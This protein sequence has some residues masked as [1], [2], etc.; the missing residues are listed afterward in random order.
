[1]SGADYPRLP[2]S[3]YA[4]AVLDN[5]LVV[6]ETRAQVR[7]IRRELGSARARVRTL[8]CEAGCPCDSPVSYQMELVR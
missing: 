6:A 5:H 7:A 1:M 2:A 4:A 3:E 8:T